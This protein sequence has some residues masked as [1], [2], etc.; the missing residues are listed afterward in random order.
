VPAL[1]PAPFFG[2]VRGLQPAMAQTH[3]E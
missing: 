1:L 3:E 2:P